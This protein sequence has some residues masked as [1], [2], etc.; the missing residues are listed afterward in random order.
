MTALGDHIAKDLIGTAAEPHQ[1]RSTV[2][3]FELPFQ[4]G[5]W[6]A[7]GKQPV[8]TEQVD[9]QIS[10]TLTQFT[11]KDFLYADFNR[12]DHAASQHRRCFITHQSRY[13]DI[14]FGLGETAAKRGTGRRHRTIPNRLACNILQILDSTSQ[15]T[16]VRES[17]AFQVQRAG[18]VGPSSIDLPD[19]VADRNPNLTEEHLVG[20]VPRPRIQWAYLNAW[21]I[22]G[23]DDHRNPAMP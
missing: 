19:E 3:T 4:R 17:A 1:R 20:S 10:Y 11:G 6:V 8:W 23:H 15:V 7:V 13:F 12:R 2:E 16:G 5:V 9:R 14:C 21:L 18:N 22:D